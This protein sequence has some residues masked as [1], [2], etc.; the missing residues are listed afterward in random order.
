MKLALVR[1]RGLP[2]PLA[3]MFAAALLCAFTADKADAALT[4]TGLFNTGVNGSGVVLPNGT[5]PDPHYALD[6]WPGVGAPPATLVSPHPNWLSNNSLSAWIGPNSSPPPNGPGGTYVYETTFNIANLGGSGLLIEGLWTTDNVGVDIRING[7]SGYSTGNTIAYGTP[8]NYSFL[9]FH[10]F[11]IL[12][13]NSILNEGS[14]SLQFVVFNGNNGNDTS[15][16][17]AVRVQFASATAALPE[18][19]S[20]AI[21][22]GF[23]LVGILWASRRRIASGASLDAHAIR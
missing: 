19:Q 20:I 11:S 14:N 4:V 22:G 9:S 1:F 12:A 5:T 2:K 17:T 7:Q 8:G 13:P 10:D 18:P 21:W 15:G 16:P 23:A 3:G 6:S